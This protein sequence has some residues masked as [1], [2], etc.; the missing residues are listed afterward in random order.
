MKS[1]TMFVFILLLTSYAYSQTSLT[2]DE[3][4]ERAEINYPLIRQRELIQK[5]KNFSIENASKGYLPQISISGQATYQSDVTQIPVEMPGVEPLSKDQYKVFGEIVQTLYH[6]GLVKQQK[7]MEEINAV[8]EEEKLAVELYQLKSRINELFFG[9]LLIQEQTAQSELVKQDITSGLKKTEAAIANGAAIRSAADVLQAEL[10]R[11]DQRIIELQSTQN[12]YKE[13]LGLFINQKI[14]DNITLQ[15]SVLNIDTRTI[16]RPELKLFDYQKQSIDINRAMLSARKKPRMELFFQGGYGRPALNM[17]ENQFD[18]F[19]LGGVRF[20]WLLSGFYT[21]GKEKQIL[22]LRQQSLDVQKETFLF[23]T[24]LTLNQHD[25]EITKLQR[26]IQVD[27]EIIALRTRIKQTASVQ[28]E[29]GVISSTDYIR[30]VNAEDQ[31]K[32]NL[33][34]HETQLLMAKAKYQF[35]SGN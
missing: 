23:N 13:I 21:Y 33:V 9:I 14:D 25:A 35:T 10:L 18:F 4:Y 31:A 7:Q 3:C 17:L 29:Q 12:A 11:V 19:Y 26:L 5:S 6:G 16:N 27:E 22:N 34:L 30:E 20:N 1:L 28:L 24:G 8:V 32:Q 15:K 2:I